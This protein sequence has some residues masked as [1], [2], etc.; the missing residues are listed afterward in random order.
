VRKYNKAK[1]EHNANPE[2]FPA[3]TKL[4]TL[5]RSHYGDILSG[6]DADEEND[7]CAY[8]PAFARAFS[9]ENNLRA[10]KFCGAVPCTRGVLK[11]PSVR[12]EMPENLET[13]DTDY[14]DPV[15]WCVVTLQ[16][17]EQRNT[18][19]CEQ[20]SALGFNGNAFRVQANRRS[21]TLVPR[22]SAITSGSDEIVEALTEAGNNLS[23]IYHAVGTMCMS[24]DEYFRSVQNK[25][26]IKEW[27]DRMKIRK[28]LV[29]KKDIELKAKAIDTSKPL[30]VPDLKLLL[31]WKLSDDEYKAQLCGSTK[32]KADLE[33]LWSTC[34]DREV[35]NVEVPED[36]PQPPPLPQ[37][38]DTAL[39]QSCENLCRSTV[40]AME[41]MKQEDAARIAREMIKRCQERGINIEEV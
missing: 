22:V 4:P 8:E 5:D 29:R 17:L 30:T 19:A 9:K 6:R 15:D 37:I 27:E 39:A 10:W 28:F 12:H 24:K 13:I 35:T 1:R 41:N 34:K 20:L 23:S 3:P 32:R 31:Q 21:R 14:A 2:L 18:K 40:A 16:E 38:Q 36:E 7:L 25:K 26:N 33:A 11:H